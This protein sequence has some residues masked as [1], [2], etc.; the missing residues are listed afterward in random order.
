M[1]KTNTGVFALR[2]F[3]AV[4]VAVHILAAAAG[5]NYPDEILLQDVYKRQVV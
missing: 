3:V 2:A 5:C 4:A 1:K